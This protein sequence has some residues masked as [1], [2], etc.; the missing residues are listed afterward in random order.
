MSFTQ[1]G[2]VLCYIT[3]DGIEINIENGLT[4]MGWWESAINLCLCGG[5]IGDNVTP[6]TKKYEWVGNEDEEP[7]N[8]FRS[9]FISLFHGRPI[10][11]Q[12]AVDL[13]GAAS[14]DLVDGF[15]AYV[16]DV[17][18]SVSIDNSEKITL[19]CEILVVDGKTISTQNE[20]YK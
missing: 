12:L 2:D 8:S 18:C 5:S 11:S 13:A 7:E 10:T 17:V 19:S 20:F 16:K 4:E 9:R 14:L 15:G 1:N 6:D 3:P